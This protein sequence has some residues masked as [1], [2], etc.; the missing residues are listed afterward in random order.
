MNLSEAMSGAEAV[1]GRALTNAEVERVGIMVD[2]NGGWNDI[3]STLNVSGE[4]VVELA[5]N[6]A[7]AALE[8]A[9]QDETAVE[10]TANE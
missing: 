4:R 1:L 2:R 5:R 7:T 3:L 6:A 8:R 10:E 9:A